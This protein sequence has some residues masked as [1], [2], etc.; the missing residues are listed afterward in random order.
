MEDNKALGLGYDSENDKLHI[1]ATV[2]F[3]KKNWKMR[4][5]EN[6]SKEEV[7]AQAPNPLTRR[8]LQRQ[9]SGLHDPLG[10]VTPVKLRRAIL[11]RRAFQ[12]VKMGHSPSE[13]TWDM[14]LS[15]GLQE[16][17]ICLLEDYA[18]I[19]KL[20]FNRALTPLGSSAEF[21][22]ITFS[23][24]SEHSYGAVLYLR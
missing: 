12:E 6:L 21:Y 3:S 5:G 9:V 20:K 1:M 16:D 2:N 22:G 24:G 17:V 8:E 7:R 18:E 15:E 23:D 4:L 13:N 11:V 10:L 14:P 19:S